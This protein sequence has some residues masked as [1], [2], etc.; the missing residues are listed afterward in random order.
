MEKRRIIAM[1]VEGPPLSSESSDWVWQ[2]YGQNR[3]VAFFGVHQ[4]KEN[5]AEEALHLASSS[6]TADRRIVVKETSVPLKQGKPVLDWHE[7]FGVE[8]CLMEAGETLVDPALAK[9]YDRL[10]LFEEIEEDG[11]ELFFL[12]GPRRRPTRLRGLKPQHAPLVGRESE[13]DRLKELLEQIAVDQGQIAGI[14]GPAGIGKTRLLNSLKEELARQSFPFA[15]GHFPLSQA[16]P[17]EGFRHIIKQMA[18][19]KLRPYLVGR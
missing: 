17:Y 15:E 14:V 6:S 1:G 10:F 18:E 13:M 19:R 4:R 8:V 7:T 11:Q 3:G 16:A 12:R 9:V 2:S 5:D